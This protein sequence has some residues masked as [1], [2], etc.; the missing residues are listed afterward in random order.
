MAQPLERVWKCRERVAAEV[1]RRTFDQST[2]RESASSRRRLPF[3]YPLLGKTAF[4]NVRRPARVRICSLLLTSLF[5]AA[6]FAAIAATFTVTSTGNSGAGTLRQAVLGVNSNAGPHTISFNISGTGPFKISL[7]SPLPAITSSVTIDGTTQPGFSNRPVVEVNGR[8]S[9]GDGLHLTAGGCVIKALAVNE[10]PGCGI[11][12]AV[13][14]SNVVQG[15]FIGTRLGGMPALHNDL[16]GLMVSNS[17]WNVLGGTTA[18][19]R[20]VVTSSGLDCVHIAGTGAISNRVLGNILGMD[21]TGLVRVGGRG[22]GIVLSNAAWNIIGGTESGA[23]NISASHAGHGLLIGG[24]NAAFNRVEGNFIGTDITGTN[25]SGNAAS[26]ITIW[27]APSNTVGGLTLGAGNVIADHTDHGIEISGGAARYNVIQGNC[28][29][30]DRSGSL[31]LHNRKAGVSSL[32]VSN[33]TVGGLIAG[34]GNTIAFN[35]QEGVLVDGGQCAILGN[36]IFDNSGSISL[37]NG[38]NNYPV[39]PALTAA[40]NSLGATRLLGRLTST[41]G[42]T[43]RI[44]FFASPT[45]A[46]DGREYLCSTSVDTDGTGL[47]TF[48][49][50]FS[51]GNISGQYA[52]ATAT[53]PFGNTS[54]FSSVR[55]VVNGSFSA[56]MPVAYEGFD[57]LIGALAG[58]AGGNGW[59]GS[60]TVQGGI[61]GS[62]SVSSGSLSDSTGTLPRAGHHATLAGGLSEVAAYRNLTSSLGS[63]GTTAWISFL[64]RPDSPAGFTYGGLVL[65]GTN[66]TGANGL[67]IGHVLS[68]YRMETSGTGTGSVV[69]GIVPAQ[70]VTAFVVAKL[71]FLPGDDRATLYIDPTPGITAPDSAYTV[72]VTNLDLG[73]FTQLKMSGGGLAQRSIDEIRIGDSYEGVAPWGAPTFTVQPQTQSMLAGLTASLS[74]LAA[75]TTPLNYQWYYNGTV[76]SGAVNETLVL[77]N[78]QHS[79]AGSYTV[80]VTNSFGTSTSQVAVVSVIG[81]PPSGLRHWWAG[82]SNALDYIGTNHGTLLNSATY[83]TGKVDSA[84]SFDGTNSAV[85]VGPTPWLNI[86]TGLTLMAWINKINVV[87]GNQFGGILGRWQETGASNSAA[88]ASNTFLFATGEG[89]ISNRVKLVLQF[90]NLNS[91]SVAGSTALPTNQWIHVAATWNSSDGIASVYLNGVRNGTT[92]L[93]VGQRLNCQPGYNAKIG[94]WGNSTVSANQFRGGI[95]E[96]MVLNRAMSSNEVYLVYSSGAAGLAK[97]PVLTAHP[98]ALVVAAGSNVTFSVT[99]VGASPLVYQ[100]NFNGTPITDATN[101][102]LLLNNVQVGDSGTYDVSVSNAAGSVRSASA[103]LSVIQDVPVITTQPISIIVVEG[104]AAMFDVT[105]VG[106][107]PLEYQWARDGSDLPGETNATLTLPNVALGDAGTF[108]VRIRNASGSILSDGAALMVQ[109]VPPIITSQPAGITVSGGSDVTFTVTATGSAPL[110]YQWAR[111]AAGISGA[112]NATLNLSNL[113]TSASYT[114]IV[115]NAAGSVTSQVAVLNVVPVPP[116]ITTQPLS[117][118]ASVGNPVTLLVAA[119]GSPVLQYQWQRNGVALAGQNTPILT[120]T[121][122]QAGNAGTYRAVVQNNEGSATS[123]G[124]DLTVVIPLLAMTDDFNLTIGSA[125]VS[126]VGQSSNTLATLEVGE[127]SHVGKRGGKSMWFAWRAPDTGIATFSTAGSDFDTLLAVYQGVAVNALV[128]L[129]SDDDDAGFYNSRVQLNVDSNAVYHIAVDGAGGVSGTIILQW[130]LE[131]TTDVLPVITNQPVSQIVGL[132]SN[133]VFTVGARGASIEYQWSFDGVPMTDGTNSGWN[134]SAAGLFDVGRYSVQVRLG[135]RTVTSRPAGLQ[136]TLTPGFSQDVLIA[137][138]FID[139]VSSGRPLRLDPPVAG[140]F[141]ITGVSPSGPSRG[142][143]GS[144]VFSTVGSL[145]EPGEPDHCGVPGGASQWFAFQAETAGVLA[146][147]TDGSTFD[148]VL[149][150]YTGPDADFASLTPLVCDNDSGTNGLTSSLHFTTTEGTTYYVAADGVNGASGTVLLNYTTLGETQQPSITITS[151]PPSNIGL[152]NDSVTISGTATDN[153]ELTGVEWRVTN[154]LGVTEWTLANGT[155]AWTFTA[156]GLAFGRNTVQIRSLDSWAN[157]SAITSRLYLRLAPL[158]VTIDGC[159][160]VSSGFLGTTYREPGK[161]VTLTATPCANSLFAG[162]AGEVVSNQTTLSLV[163]QTGLV[164]QATFVTNQFAQRPGNYA[165]LF[166]DTNIAAH[167][168]SG[169]VAARTTAKGTYSGRLRIGAKKY[170]FSG[171]FGL[172]GLAT[173]TV[174]RGGTNLPLQ[175]ELNFNPGQ[176]VQRVTGRVLDANWTAELAAF[177]AVFNT[178]TN[179]APYRGRYTLLFLSNGTPGTP[180]GL[181]YGAVTVSPNGSVR[182]SG[183]LA[184]GTALSQGTP[185]SREGLWP[186]YIPLRSGRGSIWSWLLF[187]ANTT[188]FGTNVVQTDLAGELRWFTPALPT[189]RYFPDGFTNMLDAVG[190]RYLPPISSTNGSL[191][192]SDGAVM[193]GGGNLT[194]EFT[195]DVHRAPNDRVI[196]QGTNKLSLTILRPSGLFRGSVEAPENGGTISYKGALFQN[197]DFGSG[198]FLHTNLSGPVW[199]GPRE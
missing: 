69:S 111:N 25:A 100:W 84:F 65:G 143:S 152:T 79:Q 193:F 177:R 181:G 23:G 18:L 155:N 70:G 176:L 148:T 174:R 109:P 133:A 50:L 122:V 31:D 59:A 90:T 125:D 10:F 58:S 163:I 14:P 26:G 168:S 38:A 119:T 74:A 41:P 197:G 114:V 45:S 123:A 167:E 185:V 96:V 40:T 157:V 16:H 106:A 165:G 154:S 166:Y 198:Y 9:T 98:S 192:F 85:D 87:N 72:T 42:T 194:E 68:G 60:W 112:N 141:P 187:E 43:F 189:A 17:A 34:A 32:N 52:T 11:V 132:G 179:P 29:G 199:F 30:T 161:R 1:T 86:T 126:G 128:P 160:A 6:P 19:T 175:L 95:D 56:E 53:D 158:T 44:E 15:N 139:M 3:P 2:A 71:E 7:T 4:D 48:N 83:R 47:G 49:V 37:L 164:V 108:V 5:L 134:L 129:A 121:N 113:A 182:L 89:T 64:L 36:S 101:A 190:S 127:P 186:F 151:A 104:G 28:I 131:P 99:A 80:T 107:P 153:T 169:F 88:A 93:P 91:Y 77:T 22:N 115:S 92:I 24:S 130:A 75:G 171:R 188:A 159:G 97:A 51:T 183:S 73:T 196:D 39:T 57:Y 12:L 150:V 94:S 8:S 103:E 55:T 138:K 117:Q 54:E 13:G 195:E 146:L 145:K 81:V 62:G 63:D 35:L 136:L 184:D 162:W 82:D 102:T 46:G 149:A 20:N 27:G 172:D 61:G 140:R 191:T 142:F 144:Q 124:A 33:T 120:L 67:F 118:T 156:S 178:R 21:W 105:A 78:I 116:T 76:I 147:N 173:N 137:D 135:T 170:S 66:G 110:S 180:E